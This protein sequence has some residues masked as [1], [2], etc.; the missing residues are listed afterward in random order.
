MKKIID[1]ALKV[2]LSLLLI[3]PIFGILGFFPEPT[4]DMYTNA[5]AFQFIQILMTSKYI[6]VLEALTFV[7][8]LV[9]L[10]TKRE[11]LAALLLVPFTVNI[12][13]FH[14]FLDGGLFTGGAIM[15][16]IL[17]LLNG[18]FLFK[19]KAVLQMLLAKQNV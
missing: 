16:N 17:L 4:P 7:V 14:A 5:T 8:S 9:L 6:M 18:Y 13:A 3:M 10:W 1:I 19:H 15:G 12:V 2:L 11:A